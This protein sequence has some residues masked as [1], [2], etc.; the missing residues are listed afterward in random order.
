MERVSRHSELQKRDPT[1]LI[2]VSGSSL[3]TSD[4]RLLLI[5]EDTIYAGHLS[6]SFKQRGFATNSASRVGDA[7]ERMGE[8]FPSFVVLDLML[9]SENGSQLILPLLRLNPDVRIIVLTSY[10]D[11]R[12]AAASVRLGAADVIAKPVTVDEIEHALKRPIGM[13]GSLPER[14]LLPDAACDIHI[15]EQFEKHDRNVTR[16]AQALEMHRRSLQ[17][18]LR[19]SRFLIPENRNGRAR[20]QFGRARRLARFWSSL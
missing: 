3:N 1:S 14:I 17:R 12:A 16:T 18:L 6:R 19:K 15:V 4:P 20:S 9:Q 2:R 5:L 7:L 10:A 13:S 8:A 11:L